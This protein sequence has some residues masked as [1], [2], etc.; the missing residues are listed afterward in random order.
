MRKQFKIIKGF[1]KFA[2]KEARLIP[3]FKKQFFYSGNI[4]KPAMINPAPKQ[5]MINPA[6]LSATLIQPLPANVLKQIELLIFANLQIPFCLFR[7][8]INK[9]LNFINHLIH[10]S[11]KY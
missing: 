5:I 10:N 4:A 1:G 3:C 2:K 7:L 6:V 11:E 9:L 8:I